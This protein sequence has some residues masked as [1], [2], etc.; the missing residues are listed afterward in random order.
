[1]KPPKL[2][3]MPERCFCDES[4]NKESRT[5]FPTGIV[6]D[7]FDSVIMFSNSWDRIAALQRLMFAQCA[8]QSEC[9][10]HRLHKRHCVEVHW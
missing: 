7:D 6:V 1:V 10:D 4:P 8:Y 5:E 9:A 2:F 3:V